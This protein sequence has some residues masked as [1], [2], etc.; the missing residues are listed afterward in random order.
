MESPDNRGNL[1]PRGPPP[2]GPPPL[3]L[4]TVVRVS[5]G[6]IDTASHPGVVSDDCACKTDAPGG[7]ATSANV[8]IASTDMTG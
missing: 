5:H 2:R 1:L 3:R 4:P 6:L 8:P 7:H